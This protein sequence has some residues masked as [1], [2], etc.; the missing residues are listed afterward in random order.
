MSVNIQ[1]TASTGQYVKRIKEARTV[2]DRELVKMEQQFEDFARGVNDNFTSVDGAMNSMMNSMRGVAGGGFAV[3]IGAIG[4]AAGAAVGGISMLAVETMKAQRELQNVANKAGVTVQE[5]Y[6]IGIAANTV[7]VETEKL[8]D[9]FKDLNDRIGEFSATG[10]GELKEFFDLIKGKSNVSIDDMIGKSAPENLALIASTMKEIG[11]SSQEITFVME[12]VANDA[13]VLYEV[14]KN[15]QQ[16]LADL[17]SDYA[18]KHATLSSD[19]AAEINKM[20]SNFKTLSDNFGIYMSEK[21]SE[22]YGLIGKLSKFASDSFADS[23][24]DRQLEHMEAKFRSGDLKITP[25]IDPTLVDAFFKKVNAKSLASTPRR[26][27]TSQMITSD[28]FGPDQAKVDQAQA[29][30]DAL[31][32]QAEDVNLARDVDKSNKG[33]K[34]GLASGGTNAKSIVDANDQ[35]EASMARRAKLE[36]DIAVTTANLEKA[37]ADGHT[38]YADSLN[39]QL[40]NQESNLKTNVEQ[41]RALE[42][43]R[44]GFMKKESDKREQESQKAA[45]KSLQLEKERS[46][47]QLAVMADESSKLD[48][49]HSQEVQKF[50]EMLDKKLITQAQFNAKREQLETQHQQ[51]L[52]DIE[53][54]KATERL[55]DE[56]D[57][58][59]TRVQEADA[60]LALRQQ[61]LQEKLE[62]GKIT[63]AQYN[64]AVAEARREH[65]SVMVEQDTQFVTDENSRAV[66]N[67][68]AKMMYLQEQRDLELISEQEF[69]AQRVG[70]EAEVTSA[71]TTLMNAQLDA[72]S[73]M[74]SGISGLAAAGSKEQKALF[75]IEKA[76]TIAKM[77]L[78]SY[79]AF[80]NVETD[81]SLP[82]LFAKNVARV[83]IAAQFAAQAGG[84]AAVTLG[85]FHSG[86]DEVD[87]TGSYILREGER[88]VQPTA[89]KDLTSFLKNG[90]DGGGTVVNADLIIQGGG[91]GL[92]DDRFKEYLVKHREMV[93]QAV[94]L[95]KRENPSLG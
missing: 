38:L 13:S 44:S 4:A 78:A 25:D 48:V 54:Q 57:V 42:E 6:Q 23:A 16:G 12:S 41:T 26:S 94:S 33:S 52:K 40:K 34:Q 67:A 77:S 59:T 72:F 28:S 21:F 76:A 91:D 68:E 3:G 53:N 2:S 35:I 85:Q 49:A 82:T 8:G 24:F 1:L 71:K 61:H 56:R 87:S 31:R 15:G 84:L 30:L 79:Q 69:Q 36:S 81:P 74:M 64:N 51:K 62:A 45:Q 20:D 58:A 60:D 37:K 29:Q 32:K 93:T 47:A 95:A 66:M 88:V 65:N 63:E 92:N 19:T 11:A 22:L 86:T 75:A 5:L 39:S 46:A 14:F 50:Q 17:Y 43:Q 73:N 90:G 7:G 18:T 27:S 80:A 9:V 89:N 10:S 55:Q 70:L 83:G